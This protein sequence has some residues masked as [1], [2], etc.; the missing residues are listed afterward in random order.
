VSEATTLGAAAPEQTPEPEQAGG[1]DLAERPATDPGGVPEP[2]SVDRSGP[3]PEPVPM[4]LPTQA[5]TIGS[6]RSLP[7]S[8]L[9]VAL[10][11][12]TP[13]VALDGL[14][15]GAL[16]VGAASLA[17]LSHL[18]G[19]TPR[20]DSYDL[21]LTSTGR[22]VLAIADGMGSHRHS[23]VGARVFGE[24]VVAAAAARP[25]LPAA[26][27]L[28]EAAGTIPATIAAAHGLTEDDVRFVA[29]VAVVT[30]A[31]WDIARVG[32]VSAFRLK[33]GAF[34][35]LFENDNGF[36]NVVHS[37]LPG[38]AEPVTVHSGHDGTLVLT[39]DGLAADI[40]N[41]DGVRSWLSAAWRAPLDPFAMGD[42]LRYRRQ[43]SHDDRTAVV[44]WGGQSVPLPDDP[45]AEG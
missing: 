9:A 24:A 12:R 14:R 36:V 7:P 28:V 17:G 35:E 25:D 6:V 18:L 2:G 44:V 29:A 8:E 33:D 21:A 1:R 22:L 32:D 30:D 40:R 20:Q 19:G 10:A 41:S 38:P 3:G 15:A 39:T 42:C 37:S 13:S 27:Y 34:T 31:G 11:H 26:G 45:P 5:P 23:Q 43:G 4:T 16:S